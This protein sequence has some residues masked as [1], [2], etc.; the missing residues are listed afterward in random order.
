MARKPC[1]IEDCDKPQHARG[2]CDMHYRQWQAHGHPMLVQKP[3]D[4]RPHGS[5]EDSFWAKVNKSA[6]GC[7][8]WKGYRTVWGYGFVGRDGERPPAHRV[9]YELVR[10]EI[11][12][13]LH[14]D[15]LCRNRACVN[16]DH[17]EP[18]TC[19]E[20]LLRGNGWSG[21][22]AR[23]TRCPQ[24]HPYS[25]DNTIYGTKGERRCLTCRREYDRRRRPR[26]RG[27]EV[28]RKVAA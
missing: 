20:N 24:G 9:A 19:R 1:S 11:P 18:V 5:F 3:G 14:L 2:W 15:H 7:W 23:K 16:P 12:E 22:N 26:R 10:G 21:R 28:E 25:D 4:D 6:D 8:E 13:G 17:L 27:N